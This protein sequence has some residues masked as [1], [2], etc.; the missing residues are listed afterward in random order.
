MD[1]P[2]PGLCLNS[3]LLRVFPEEGEGVNS[4]CDCTREEECCVDNC[5]GGDAAAAAV[6]IDVVD[7]ERLKD[8]AMGEDSAAWSTLFLWS[9]FW[10]IL[11]VFVFFSLLT[12]LGEV[13][14]GSVEG[15]FMTDTT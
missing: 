12:I 13:R 5:D 11:G 1:V 10:N 14:S 15:E 2:S 6:G 8:T 4:C 7:E 3:V 9:S